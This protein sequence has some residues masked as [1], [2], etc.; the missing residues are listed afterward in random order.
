ML[1]IAQCAV[2][3]EYKRVWWNPSTK[4]MLSCGQMVWNA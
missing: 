4:Q 1:W 3:S 2:F